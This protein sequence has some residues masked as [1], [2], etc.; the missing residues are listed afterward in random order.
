MAVKSI[1][2]ECISTIDDE[3]SLLQ[4]FS[5]RNESNSV[6]ILAEH[7]RHDLIT[8]ISYNEF[9][10]NLFFDGDLIKIMEYLQVFGNYLNGIA[11]VLSNC[12]QVG[13]ALKKYFKENLKISEIILIFLK[14]IA[15]ITNSS[16]IL[17]RT[18]ACPVKARFTGNLCNIIFG[19]YAPSDFVQIIKQ[20]QENADTT[21]TV[22][23]RCVIINLLKILV[24]MP[25]IYCIHCIYCKDINF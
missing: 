2:Y 9:E 19:L 8:N 5:N 18:N 17:L 12:N 3:T 14:N 24:S 13:Q 11:S 10:Y 6:E 16:N 25:V 22:Y 15:T 20:T 4:C 7:I 1:I 21:N 23:D